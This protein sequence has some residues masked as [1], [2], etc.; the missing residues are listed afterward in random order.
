MNTTPEITLDRDDCLAAAVTEYVKAVE[1][2]QTVAAEAW[3][4]RYPEVAG[5]LA[6][7]FAAH[8]EVDRLAAPLRTALGAATVPFATSE[9][10]STRPA[11]P[12]PPSF[13]DYEVLEEIGRSG[14]GVVY[15]ARQRSLNRLVALKMVRPGGRTPDDLRRFLRA[16]AEMAASLEH[17]H[18]VPVHE[19]GE[20]DGQPYL[21]M[22][23]IEG[24]TLAR[25]LARREQEG[26]P[27]TLAAEVALLA[28]VA[29][30]VHH[31]HQ[32]G[33]L[34]RD[35]KPSNILLNRAGEPFVTDFGLA[36]RIEGEGASAE[37][38]TIAGTP[39]Y[40]APEQT[41]GQARLTTAVDVW[42]LG[43][44]LYELLTGQP[45]FRGE[46]VLDTLAQV[47]QQEPVRPRSLRRSLD[48]D[49]ETICLKCLAKE[50]QR[51]YGS[52]EALAEDLERWQKGE[53][54]QAHRAGTWERTVKWA[55]RRPAVAALCALALLSAGAVLGLAAWG[56][57]QT[58]QARQAAEDRAAAEGEARRA[59]EGKTRQAERHARVLTASLALQRGA[60]R[61]EQGEYVR[62]LLWL[63][64][65]LEA[66]PEDA[67]ELQRQLRLLLGGWSG[68]LH[69]LVAELPHEHRVLDSDFIRAAVFSPDGKTLLT[70][71]GA[72]GWKRR[73]CQL[74]D[75]T[76]GQRRGR[77]LT[78]HEGEVTAMTFSPDG[79]FI[80]T[81][82]D[83]KVAR[84]WGV[85]RGG[86][87]GGPWPHA[88]P[89]RAIA[90]TPDG[91]T[92]AV[93]AG[94]GPAERAA[95]G[96]VRLW[97]TASGLPRGE[98]IPLKIPPGQV[99]FSPD[100]KLLLVQVESQAMLSES[101][102]LRF[103]IAGGKPLAP[104]EHS[105][106]IW[107]AA[108]EG[109]DGPAQKRHPDRPNSGAAITPDG[110]TVL[111]WGWG[112]IAPGSPARLHDDRLLG[113]NVQWW[114]AATGEPAGPPTWLPVFR[115]VGT[116][117]RVIAFSPDGRGA[118]LAAETSSGHDFSALFHDRSLVGQPQHRPRGIN[119][120]AFSPDGR[121]LVT[122]GPDATARP[123][124]ARTGQPLGV[125][126]R[127]DNFHDAVAYSSNRVTAVAFS[128]DGTRLFT[129]SRGAVRLWEVGSQLALP[130]PLRYDRPATLARFSPDGTRVALTHW[131]SGT[132][133]RVLRRLSL[134]ETST[135]RQLGRGKALA[136]RVSEALAFSPNGKV[137]AAHCEDQTCLSF[138]DAVTGEPLPRVGVQHKVEEL[139]RGVHEFV[140]APD[141]R[142]VLSRTNPADY[143]RSRQAVRV[144]RWDVAT[145]K[146]VSRPL[147][148]D[149]PG[150]YLDSALSPDG[151]RLFL[152]T[153]HLEGQVWKRCQAR[154]W[155]MET[156]LAVGDP[157]ALPV[158][159]SAGRGV[160]SAD[161]KVVVVF[162]S[163]RSTV[164]AWE[165]ATGKALG[166]AIP[167]TFKDR[168][169]GLL[170]VVSADGKTILTANSDEA[171]VW[172]AVT[173]KPRGEPLTVPQDHFFQDATFSPDARVILTV[174]SGFG[175]APT[176]LKGRFT[177]V[178]L[179]EAV[180]LRQLGPPLRGPS[181]AAFSPDGKTFLEAGEKEVWL[182]R[183]PAPLRGD[184]ERIR[185]WVEVNTGQALDES[186]A[187]LK[188]DATGLRERWQRLQ[189][190]GGMPAP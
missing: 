158:D 33:I 106:A 66:A 159:G 135:G 137:L 96:E 167:I 87:V 144:C 125:P 60:T 51:R 84:L 62:G 94:T 40:M 25:R 113:G 13:G 157:L 133:G 86:Q 15:K 117:V 58:A 127:H 177:E 48:R 93:A 122:G 100:G 36:K 22:Q 140:F 118:L 88:Y 11:L 107:K 171:R 163:L 131:Y 190:L 175:P 69:P 180:T 146:L 172:D 173:G 47:R 98:P 30:A 166:P 134:W 6:D 4:A 115:Y 121:L 54:I 179:W 76:T 26:S 187:V 136:Q 41:A 101:R 92:A 5:E 149:T 81:G 154:L 130:R 34:H 27:T 156:G 111:T 39:L 82:G 138:W 110:R 123:W 165:A 73:V 102:V 139:E 23:L 95:G 29:R 3:L 45:P 153:A 20:C 185:L 21:C 8:A 42:G 178:R 184:P 70:A 49:L 79:R 103:D 17:P 35:L 109:E 28:C 68:Q 80:L 9:E 72:E 67:E 19:V 105:A 120:A 43:A 182:R 176:E 161:S 160:F 38:G 181:A 65:G 63:A 12:A 112:E 50:P 141:G 142:T 24:E 128:P 132:D 10:G 114:D 152:T 18:I 7:F 32:R 14:M 83:D 75:V 168:I 2:G 151:R 1:A 150:E 183:V 74:W 188:L 116:P 57:S 186:G 90:F 143:P 129:A 104:L 155:D 189:K 59:A 52:A 56:W 77:P 164:R 44:I 55:R 89:V 169:G 147:V 148:R 61:C 108:L 124:D 162:H 145:G 64:R 126:L 174:N 97:E 170:T 119:A 71:R 53:P 16:E 91:K 78:P 37:S 99:A 85:A 31:A 46:T